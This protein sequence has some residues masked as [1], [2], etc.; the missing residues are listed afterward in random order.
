MVMKIIS[1]RKFVGNLDKM[2]VADLGRQRH[3]S[4]DSN[5][6]SYCE[7]LYLFG[8]ISFYFIRNILLKLV[9]YI[10]KLIL[11]MFSDSFD[12]MTTLCHLSY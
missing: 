10:F 8:V 6:K 2:I 5:F 9:V 11:L 7:Y 1:F 3:R 12:N 4:L